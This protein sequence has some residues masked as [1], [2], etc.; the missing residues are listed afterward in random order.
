MALAR[1]LAAVDRFPQGEA[2]LA[3]TLQLAR[4]HGAAVT[5]AH[6][7]DVPGPLPSLDLGETLRAQLERGA[8]DRIE[9]ALGGLDGADID[10]D[11]RIVLGHAVTCLT[12]LARDVGAGL[13]VMGAHQGDRLADRILGSTTDRVMASG[14]VPL[15][16]VRAGIAPP[17]ARVLLAADGGP[18]DEA[19][20]SF[21][22][23]LLP[24][25]SLHLVQAVRIVQQLEEAILRIG[26]G[27]EEMEAHRRAIADAAARNLREL[28]ATLDR[29][30]TLRVMQ[31]DPADAIVRAARRRGSDL[32]VLGRGRA[33]LFRRAFVGSVARRVVRDAPCDVLVCRPPEGGQSD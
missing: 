4:A 27:P 19:A 7:I 10:I 29:P 22:A 11:V 2:V 9:A 16:V 13:M 15:L 3:R 33:G 18:S 26:T 12:D 5:I 24:Q 21:A 23:G 32:I 31:G 20:L 28:A 17:H 30:V 1:L 8:R 25:A 14:C 6:V